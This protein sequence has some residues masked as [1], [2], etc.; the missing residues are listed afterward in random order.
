MATAP[1]LYF[2]FG[3][4][5]FYF[6]TVQDPMPIFHR[7]LGALLF[8][9]VFLLSWFSDWV[10]ERLGP[11]TYLITYSALA[12]L[13][14]LNYLQD[15]KFSLAVSLVV[16]VALVNLFFM[17][18]AVVLY[19]NLLLSLGVA[20]TL[21]LTDK[22]LLFCLGY[23]SNYLAVAGI[24]YFV[25]YQK[26]KNKNKIENMKQQLK[27]KKKELSWELEYHQKYEKLFNN[28]NS[29]VA[30]YKPIND[31]ENFIF[32]D[33][34]KRGQTMDNLSKEEIINKKVTA[35]FPGVE[36]FGLLAVLQRVCRTGEAEEHPIKKYEDE[37]ITAYRE[38]YVYKLATGEIVSVYRDIT[39]QKE[40]ERK[41][42]ETKNR[43]QLAIEGANLG[44][45]DWNNQSGAVQFNDKWAEMLG[46]ELEDLKSDIR[47]WQELMHEADKERVYEQLEQHLQGLTSDY[48]SEHRL[49]TKDGSWKWIKDIGRVV[50]RDEEGTPLRTVGIHQDIDARKRAEQRAEYLAFH[51]KL[52]GLYNRRY[53]ENERER[54]NDSRRL[55]ISI[56][57]ADMNKL[58]FVND[59][60]GH[61]S[62]DEYIKTAA[63][64]FTSVT[65]KEDVVA[66]IGGDEFAV[67]LPETDAATAEKICNRFYEQLAEINA[68]RKSDKQLGISLG[69]ATMIDQQQD[70]TEIFEIA[71]HR[72]Y[73]NKEGK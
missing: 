56:I 37:R 1:C 40:Q 35:I 21:C 49:K 17:G 26:L 33:I 3:V 23:Y 12:H 69:Y 52:T 64:V 31:G 68:V 15:Y 38:N 18:N 22:P 63:E 30:V 24:T 73:E 20:I 66:R 57:V 7:L 34:N 51:D 44:L 43:L 41:L 14:I 27:E 50:E 60:Y 55:P 8:L 61:Q 65:R 45:W 10:K 16:V 48:E 46:Y 70:L 29:G 47:T 42:K 67:L 9:G 25:S 11:L 39:K 2:L 13:V 58:K 54:L 5:Y 36:E 4:F 53:F 62:G 72:M 6:P 71:D 32:T 59:N 19:S 28:I